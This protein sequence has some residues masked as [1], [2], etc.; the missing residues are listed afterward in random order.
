MA[1]AFAHHLVIGNNVPLASLAAFF[2][3]ICRSLIIE[4]VPKEDS[5][6]QRMLAL[7]GD[8]CPDYTPDGFERAFG[9][10]FTIHRSVAIEGTARRVY[11]MERR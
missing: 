3:R 7:R 6:V 4:F 8:V 10:E 2:R 1:L 5:Q 11:L 9:A